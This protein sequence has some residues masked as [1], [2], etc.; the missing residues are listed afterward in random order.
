MR[1]SLYLIR[2]WWS[3]WTVIII[4]A[5]V[6]N[7][8]NSNVFDQ[9]KV[10]NYRFQFSFEHRNRGHDELVE[11]RIL[12]RV[13]SLGGFLL[14]LGSLSFDVRKLFALG[15]DFV[16]MLKTSLQYFILVFPIWI[17]FLV[18][19]QCIIRLSLHSSL[20]GCLT[21]IRSHDLSVLCLNH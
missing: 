13:C 11:L 7:F 15:P 5:F 16:G 8:H 6:W 12:Q 21:G 17:S 3:I 18:S 19:F 4:P 14:Q 1:T 2:W 10:E 9:K 20:R